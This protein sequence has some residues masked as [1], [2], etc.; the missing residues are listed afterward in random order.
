[1]SNNSDSITDFQSMSNNFQFIPK[2]VDKTKISYLE[3]NYD[4]LYGE[5][6]KN[7]EDVVVIINTANKLNSLVLENLGLDP[8]S[9]SIKFEEVIGKEF[10]II[11]NEIIMFKWRYFIIT[12]D[13]NKAYEKK[14][15]LL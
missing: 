4:L 14:I 7:K 5:Y 1:M 15:I 2:H 13:L 8:N 11:T 10:K 3:K 6:P 9:E 12:N